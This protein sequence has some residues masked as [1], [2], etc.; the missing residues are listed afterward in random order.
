MIYLLIAAMAFTAWALWNQ[1]KQQ[2]AAF[3]E[4]W[5][6]ILLDKV[7]YYKA[8]DVEDRKEFEVRMRFFLSEV[9]I[10]GVEV[11]VEDE[12]RVLIGASAIIPVFGFP[13]WEYHNVDNIMLYPG[14]FDQDFGS[15][16]SDR[17]IRGMVGTGG[18]MEGRMVLS[19]HALRNGFSNH[20]DKRNTAVH[21]FVHLID[22]HDGDIDGL[23][24][25]IVKHPY[26]IPWL[27]LIRQKSTEIRE[28][29]SDIDGYAATDI[30]EFLSVASEYFFERPKLMAKKHP[31]L[32]EKLRSFFNQDPA[33]L[34]LSPIKKETGRNEP[35]PCGSG[36]KYKHCHFSHED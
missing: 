30:H 28:G 3:P 2:E 8:L 34:D 35:C 9:K 10:E 27:E 32:Y 21:E 4:L 26:S 33:T 24:D 15:D 6:K 36:K 23:P 14:N 22:K 11:E 13:N 7:N 31:L 5:R 17:H 1:K 12:D 20:S 16:G 18:Y 25:M 19:Q 29:K